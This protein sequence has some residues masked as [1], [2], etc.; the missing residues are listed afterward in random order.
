M[1]FMS[2]TIRT[3]K[4]CIIQVATF[5]CVFMPDAC[6]LTIHIWLYTVLFLGV[7]SD[8]MNLI[9]RE[10]FKPKSAKRYQEGKSQ[11]E[12]IIS[13]S[14]QFLKMLARYS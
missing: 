6:Y 11:Q 10:E 5:C 3:N 1:L 9:F 7:F 2:L 12:M 14:L 8:M 4:Y 13:A